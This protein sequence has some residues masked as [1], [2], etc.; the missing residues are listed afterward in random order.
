MPVDSSSHLEKGY[1]DNDVGLVPPQCQLLTRPKK[2][3]RGLVTYPYRIS[4]NSSDT[5]QDSLIAR[6][7]ARKF[8]RESDKLSQRGNEFDSWNLLS[9]LLFKGKEH[10]E[11]NHDQYGLAR[12]FITSLVRK[13]QLGR[14]KD[15][16]RLV[17]A[18][19]ENFFAD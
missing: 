19:S 15:L 12:Q 18:I 14:K 6:S 1:P 13:R 9:N 10:R 16:P 2:C 3:S 5:E 4:A 17:N 11:G 8:S 7:S